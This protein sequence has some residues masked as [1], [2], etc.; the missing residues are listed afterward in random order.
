MKNKIFAVMI[1]CLA[2]ANVSACVQNASKNDS[3]DTSKAPENTQ[4]VTQQNSEMNKSESSQIEELQKQIADLQQQINEQNKQ[5]S[6]VQPN[7]VQQN[8]MQNNMQGTTVQGITV[9]EAKAKATQHAGFDVASVTFVKQKY[10]FDDG[11][12]KWEIEFVVDTNKYEYDINAATGDIV[13][14]QVESIYDD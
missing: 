13:K 10:D 14:Y 8:Q 2:I 6:Q 7:Q 11:I 12:A 5:G 3:V 9:D 4:D 1:V